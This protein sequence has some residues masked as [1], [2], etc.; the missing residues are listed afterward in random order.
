MANP[1]IP[2]LVK[3]NVIWIVGRIITK[4]SDPAKKAQEVIDIC[5]ALKEINSGDETAGLASLEA[6]MDV[7]TEDPAKAMAI[8]NAIV[9]IATKIS[10]IKQFTDGTIL[11]TLNTEIL[12][13]AL[14]QAVLVAQKYIKPA[15]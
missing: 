7:S 6:A 5:G 11:G 14:D 3:M 2:A 13:G 12:D 4:A 10:A 9:F 8:Q 15:Q 1:N